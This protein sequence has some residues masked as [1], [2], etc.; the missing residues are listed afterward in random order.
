MVCSMRPLPI[1]MTVKERRVMVGV[2]GDDI[3]TVEKEKEREF[4]E[5]GN[6]LTSGTQVRDKKDSIHHQPS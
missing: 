6:D 2:D 4:I 3:N 1:K 5:D